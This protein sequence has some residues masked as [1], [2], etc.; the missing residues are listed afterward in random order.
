MFLWCF[1]LGDTGR[2]V[3]YHMI[4]EMRIPPHTGSEILEAMLQAK[5]QTTFSITADS[6]FTSLGFLKTHPD[7][8]LIF[9][10]SKSKVETEVLIFGQDLRLHEY[11]VFTK[12]NLHIS[13]WLDEAL[14]ICASNNFREQGQRGRGP[15]IG[16]DS[17][18]V[19]PLLS[20]SDVSKL[21]QLSSEGLSSLAGALGV[22][23]SK[24]YQTEGDPTKI[25]KPQKNNKKQF[26][27]SNTNHK[28]EPR[29]KLPI[30]LA[31]G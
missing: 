11:R 4:P 15:F 13:I 23:K 21:E 5:P 10:L 3:L 26:S 8:P 14:L 22:R 29:G 16:V 27:P 25:N 28:V 1:F 31:E 9:A 18:P 7:V 19:R 24:F 30:P 6:W 12:G 20:E 17:D 2:P